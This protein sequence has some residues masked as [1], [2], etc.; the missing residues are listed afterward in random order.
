MRPDQLPGC[1]NSDGAVAGRIQIKRS[2][3]ARSGYLPK[4]LLIALPLTLIEF[5]K[6]EFLGLKYICSF[7]IER[8][9]KSYFCWLKASQKP[10]MNPFSASA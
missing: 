8:S 5:P 9:L 6:T 7:E 10:V 2:K 1:G 3:F 4:L